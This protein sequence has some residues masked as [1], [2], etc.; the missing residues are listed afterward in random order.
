MVTL[1]RQCYLISTSCRMGLKCDG[2]RAETR[3]RLSTKRTSPFKSAGASVQS[4]TG[5]RGVRTSGS[6]AGYTTFRGSVKSTGYLLN[7]PVSPSLSLPRVTVCHHI[8]TGFYLAFNRRYS[9]T[10]IYTETEKV[11]TTIQ[12]DVLNFK[13]HDIV[14]HSTT[15]TTASVPFAIKFALLSFPFWME[16]NLNLQNK[17][18]IQTPSALRHCLSRQYGTLHK[19]K[20]YTFR[21]QESLL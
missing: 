16:S 5:S 13:A 17:L 21:L 20:L 8:S 9:M 10:H 1:T 14:K 3:F 18:E 7:S 11:P 6:N 15:S 19:Q 4:L 2:T 12:R